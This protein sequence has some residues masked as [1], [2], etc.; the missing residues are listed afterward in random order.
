M[1]EET[2]DYPVGYGRPPKHTQFKAGR[3][4]NPKGR[5]KGATNFKTD[6]QEELSETIRV[7]EG[8]RNLKVSKQRAMIKALMAKAL[9]GDA[10]AANVLITHIAKLVEPDTPAEGSTALSADDQAILERFIA[11]RLRNDRT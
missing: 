9:K 3:S 5:P 6:L 10:R 1:T 7:R 8:D 11:A 4:G 2:E